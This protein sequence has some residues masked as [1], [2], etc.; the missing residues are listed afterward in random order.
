VTDIINIRDRSGH[1]D[2]GNVRPSI[3]RKLAPLLDAAA[4][5]LVESELARARAGDPLAR[6]LV[7]PSVIPRP[8]ALPI[9][10]PEVAAAAAAGASPDA[11]CDLVERAMFEGRI[12][13]SQAESM[14]RVVMRATAAAFENRLALVEAEQRREAEATR[15]AI[16]RYGDAPCD[17]AM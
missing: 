17:L 7:I 6:R 4:A 10:L 3:K 13:P 2:K 1:F 8:E 12:S 9:P 15:A 11:R 14:V 5:D 16:D